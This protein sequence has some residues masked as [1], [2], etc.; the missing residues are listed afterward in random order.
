MT[1]ESLI[2]QYPHLLIKEVKTLPPGLAGLYMD[3]VVL[4]DKNRGLYEKHCILAEEIG[5][6]ETT[7]GDITDLQKLTNLK[8]ELLARRWGYEKIVSLDKLIECHE[9]GFKTVE[10]VCTH[11]EV[12]EDYL[13]TSIAHYYSRFGVSTSYK[14]YE[15]FF[16]PLYLRKQ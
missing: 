10:E 13:K 7:Y 16:D 5:H 1:Y 4:I 12:T 3:D 8:L 11:L 2:A 15:I 6:Y 14:G 9:L